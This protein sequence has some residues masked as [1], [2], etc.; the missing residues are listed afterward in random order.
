MEQ[1]SQKDK[2][3]KGRLKDISNGNFWNNLNGIKTYQA[4]IINSFAYSLY[5]LYVLVLPQPSSAVLHTLDTDVIL[6]PTK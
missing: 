4:A 2:K 5:I 6:C 3:D 1:K